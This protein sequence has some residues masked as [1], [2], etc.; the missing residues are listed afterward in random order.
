MS[1]ERVIKHLDYIQDIVNRM[2]R[3]S[4]TIK[5]FSIFSLF[6][7]LFLLNAFELKEYYQ[8]GIVGLSVLVY[9]CLDTYF[10]WQERMFRSEYNRVRLENYTDSTINP[11]QHK[12][13]HSRIDVFFSST[14]FLP[15]LVQIVIVLLLGG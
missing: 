15:Y 11:M 6:A 13:D 8:I 10:L 7:G 12:D 4:F 9:W 5:I 2:A 3:N 14:L 1:N